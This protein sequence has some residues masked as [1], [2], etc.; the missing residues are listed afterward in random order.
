VEPAHPAYGRRGQAAGVV[1]PHV[2]RAP[3]DRRPA[4]RVHVHVVVAARGG[5]R[6]HRAGRHD[7][8]PRPG[9]SQRTDRMDRG[10]TGDALRP[11]AGHVDSPGGRPGGELRQLLDGGPRG[12]DHGS[13][14]HAAGLDSHRR[15]RRDLRGVTP[16]DPTH[17]GPGRRRG[18][19]ALPPARWGVPPGH[20]VGAHVRDHADPPAL[21]RRRFPHAPRVD[22]ADAVHDSGKPAGDPPRHGVGGPGVPLVRPRA[23]QGAGRQPSRGRRDHRDP[24]PAPVRGCSPTTASPSR[25]FSPGTPPRHP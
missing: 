3:A 11:G 14:R 20:A 5:C 25:T 15:H 6:R 19:S 21:G 9:H 18:R 1:V 12:M 13:L 10:R 2:P 16:A 4:T 17:P 22:R 8:T 24:A 7:R 23:G